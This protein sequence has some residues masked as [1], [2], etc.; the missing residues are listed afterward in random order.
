MSSQGLPGRADAIN[1]I[2]APS[3]A[4]KPWNDTR[5]GFLA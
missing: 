5:W 1:Q 4:V 3:E 2:T